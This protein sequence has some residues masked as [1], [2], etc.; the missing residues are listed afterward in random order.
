MSMQWKPNTTVAA[1]VYQ[2]NRFLMVEEDTL[3]GV[4][5]NQPAGH[6]EENETLLEAVVRETREE[7]AYAITPEA[8]LGIYQWRHPQKALTYM[9]FAFIGQVNAHYPEQA[10]D[11]GIRRAIWM[12]LAEIEATQSI[13]RS[14]QVLLCIR[15]F[16]AGKRYPLSI[17]THLQSAT[18]SI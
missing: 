2:D 16:L 3:D 9:R 11:Q 5:L 17:I 15:D 10:L 1:I 13:H 14:P 6:L 18:S 4:R 8:L 7:S 12:T